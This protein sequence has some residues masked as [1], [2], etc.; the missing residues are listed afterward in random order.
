MNIK[1]IVITV[2]L[3]AGIYVNLLFQDSLAA[4]HDRQWQLQRLNHPSAAQ[5]AAERRGRVTIYDGL[6]VSEVEHALDHQF[7]RMGAMMFVR[8]RFPTADGGFA[9][10]NECD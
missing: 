3:L 7:E 2:C 10:D 9:S 4:G 5:L 6:E 8:T 1:D